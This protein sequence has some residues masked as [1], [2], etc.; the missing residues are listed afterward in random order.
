MYLGP[1]CFAWLTLGAAFTE[2]PHIR[3]AGAWAVPRAHPALFG[4]AALTGFAINVCAAKAG[5]GGRAL[6]LVG[7]YASQAKGV[8]GAGAHRTARRA[9]GRPRRGQRPWMTTPRV[10]PAGDGP[11]RTT[12]P[13]R[14][15]ARASPLRR[16][17][18]PALDTGACFCNNQACQQPNPQGAGRAAGQRS[19]HRSAFSNRCSAPTHAAWLAHAQPQCPCLRAPPSAGGPTPPP[20]LP[21]E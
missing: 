3:E 6:T 4:T 12:K 15:L 10:A 2:W 13:A 14:S 7:P 11:R 19:I 20:P 8:G 1:A 9:G 17:A 5:G 18:A 21:R 16:R